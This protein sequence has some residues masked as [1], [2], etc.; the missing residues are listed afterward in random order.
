[1]RKRSTGIVGEMI[2][3]ELVPMS[4]SCKQGGDEIRLTPYAY[5]TDLWASIEKMLDDNHR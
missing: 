2:A 1:M 5:I 4:F 3:A